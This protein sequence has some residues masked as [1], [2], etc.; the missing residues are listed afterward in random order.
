MNPEYSSGSPEADRGRDPGDIACPDSGGCGYHERLEG[1]KS[2]FVAA[3]LG[4]NAERFDKHTELDKACADGKPDAR[5]QKKD[6]QD[7]A[8]K[9]IADRIDDF[10]KQ[11]IFLSF[12]Q[13]FQ[14]RC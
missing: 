6:D 1:R 9:E 14:M 13:R 12:C 7:V 2:V 10:C 4:H 11:N 5:A 8:V 3:R